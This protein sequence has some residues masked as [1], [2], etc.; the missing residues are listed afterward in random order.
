[1]GKQAAATVGDNS[2]AIAKEELKSFVDRLERLNEEK[3]AIVN[4]FKDVMTEARSRGYDTKALRTIIKMRKQD[5]DERRE[6]EA[7]LEI[8]MHAL[9]MLSDLPLGQA[10]IAAATRT[11][12]PVK[13]D[14]GK[15]LDAG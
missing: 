5:T 14:I 11:R 15:I 7:I 13:N 1:M 3:Q 8:Y 10:A 2:H 6:Q 4:D 9:G 12:Q